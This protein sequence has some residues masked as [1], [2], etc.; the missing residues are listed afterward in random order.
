MHP[1]LL[2]LFGV[3]LAIANVLLGGPPS[4]EQLRTVEAVTLVAYDSDPLFSGDDGQE[5]TL[6]L[7]L[8]VAY[9][10]GSMIP[11]ITGD[12]ACLERKPVECSDKAKCEPMCVKKGPPQSFCTFQ[13]HVS[14]GG[15][16]ALADDIMA[17]TRKGYAMLKSSIKACRAHPIAWYASGPRGCEDKRAQ[18]ISDDRMNL[19]ASSRGKA[20]TRYGWH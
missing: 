2:L 14:A 9:R 8:A 20:K 16:Q 1:V 18:G 17:C 10:E 4:T 15:T 3:A 11:S 13:I 19:A 12:G 5:R 6:A 7:M